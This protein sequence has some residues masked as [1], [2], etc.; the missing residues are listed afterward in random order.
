MIINDIFSSFFVVDVLDIDNT[1]IINFC[2]D[3]I[4]CSGTNTGSLLLD[5]S[6]FQ[7]LLYEAKQRID[8]VH[9]HI[10]LSQQ[11]EQYIWRYWAN[12]NQTDDIAAP[13]CHP[14]SFLSCVYYAKAHG[15]SSG[16]LEFLTPSNQMIPVVQNKMI[17]TYTKYI[18]PT[19]WIDPEP[20]KLIIFPS[21]LWHFVN[22]NTSGQDR[23]SIAIDTKVRIKNDI[24]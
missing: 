11:Y 19:W 14:E 5:E 18:A 24:E 3:N 23:I 17:D 2:Y 9:D 6:C 1:D 7:E 15:E 20:G 8:K 22:K 13:H 10:G 21:W 12:L 4:E 16:R